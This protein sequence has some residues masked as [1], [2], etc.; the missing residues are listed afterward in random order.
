MVRC[1]L[2]I[3][4][5]AAGLLEEG[6]AL[7]I[8]P[9]QQQLTL[10]PNILLIVADDMSP[11]LVGAYGAAQ[12]SSFNMTPHLDSFAATAFRFDTAFTPSPLCSPS[13]FSLMTGRYNSRRAAFLSPENLTAKASRHMPNISR[14]MPS[15]QYI[16]NGGGP[17]MFSPSEFEFWNRRMLPARLQQLGYR[18]GG[19]GKWHVG[20]PPGDIFNRSYLFGGNANDAHTWG[21]P[22]PPA[23]VHHNPEEITAQ[24]LQFLRESQA[25]TEPFFLY[26]AYTLTHAPVGIERILH[27]DPFIGAEPFLE[28]GAQRDNVTGLRHLSYDVPDQNRIIQSRRDLE[29]SLDAKKLLK[30]PAN[31][32][33]VGAAQWFDL[34]VGE[35]LDELQAQGL[36]EDTLV[37]ITADHGINHTSGGLGKGTPYNSGAVVPLM[38]RVPVGPS[39]QGRSRAVSAPVS[40]LDLFPTFLDFAGA[41]KP[42]DGLDGRS[43]LPQLLGLAEPHSRVLFVEVGV[44]RAVISYPWKLVTID[45]GLQPGWPSTMESHACQMALSDYMGKPT[46]AFRFEE[47]FVELPDMCERRQLYHC[48]ARA[49][50]ENLAGSKPG[51]VARLS[52][53]LVE[54][55]QSTGELPEGE[56]VV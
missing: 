40:T 55:L 26:V 23:A 39:A 8:T 21:R 50:G 44:T 5:C 46:E 22:M 20:Q 1:L 56:G 45:G 43:L 35:I 29:V 7:H 10:Q 32:G 17:K 2:H 11:A 18:T 24:A 31:M 33:G 12:F 6:R 37:V 54:H 53:L 27:E 36:M 28:A 52:Q 19:I 38:I 41:A 9:Q 25:G 13:R 51:Q 34:Q 14:A 16:D 42:E 48:G 49:E 3:A 30:G 15:L 47:L 4:M